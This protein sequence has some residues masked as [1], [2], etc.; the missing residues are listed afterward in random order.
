MNLLYEICKHYHTSCVRDLHEKIN[1]ILR[2]KVLYCGGWRYEIEV[3]QNQC[4]G[5][6]FHIMILFSIPVLTGKASIRVRRQKEA[7]DSLET[8]IEKEWNQSDKC[9]IV[10][11]GHDSFLCC[12]SFLDVPRQ[13][14]RI[15]EV[16]H[17]HSSLQQCSK[18]AMNT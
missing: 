18:G 2:R 8:E 16:L 1:N 7:E 6:D 15:N 12:I 10:L 17:S 5:L 9:S 14:M 4:N 11:K 13:K 3:E